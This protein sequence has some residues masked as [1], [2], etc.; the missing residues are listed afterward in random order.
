M[1]QATI[2][3]GYHD[4][5]GQSCYPALRSAMS[6]IP[7]PLDPELCKVGW[8]S[9]PS[10]APRLKQR[11]R[12]GGGGGGWVALQERGVRRAGHYGVDGSCHPAGATPDSWPYQLHIRKY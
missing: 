3:T 2:H 6:G 1:D 5:R 9:Q 4:K 12:R 10:S 11:V 7:F 8:G